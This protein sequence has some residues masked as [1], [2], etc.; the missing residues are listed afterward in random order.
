MRFLKRQRR[1]PFVR[2]DSEA[3]QALTGSRGPAT[4]PAAAVA[5]EE[6]RLVRIGL[7]QRRH[8]A[9]STKFMDS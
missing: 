8:H 2:L 6:S 4:F 9:I 7:G 3:D 1:D 5:G